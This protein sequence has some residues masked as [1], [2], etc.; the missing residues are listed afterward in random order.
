MGILMAGG[1]F[2]GANPTYVARELAY[3]LKDSDAKFL[4]AVDG[5]LDVAIDATSQIGMSKDRVFIFDDAGFEGTGKGRHGIR[6]WNTLFGSVEEANRFVWYDVKDPRE[7][8]CC[9]NYS[10]GTTGVPKGV[11]ITHYNYVANGEQ[12]IHLF[13]LR[14][15]YEERRKTERWLCML[16][17]YHAYGNISSLLPDPPLMVSGQTFFIS[18]SPKIGLPIYIMPKFDF[19]KM[20][21]HIQDFRVTSLTLAPPIAVA[22]AKHPAVKNYDLSSIRT[23]ASGAAPLSQSVAEEVNN[24]WEPGRINLK[25][26]PPKSP[27]VCSKPLTNAPHSKDGA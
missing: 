5:S 20:L 12:V 2:T 17:M 11:M 4:I 18:I 6:N 10:S 19:I 24:L 9:L 27:L 16:P 25:A 22:L 23:A 21:E 7:T 26:R 8:I 13:S 14:P 1:I 3:Q 15:D